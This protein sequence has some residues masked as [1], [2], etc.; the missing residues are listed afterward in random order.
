MAYWNSLFIILHRY[1]WAQAAFTGP[2]SYH[3]ADQEKPGSTSCAK[4]VPPSTLS[5][6]PVRLG[7]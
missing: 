7:T 2:T 3:Q 5:T 6:R 1:V 4:L